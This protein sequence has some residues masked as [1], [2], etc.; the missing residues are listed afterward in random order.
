MI[1]ITGFIHELFARC[2]PSLASIGRWVERVLERA[3]AGV[4]PFELVL[5]RGGFEAVLVSCIG[6]GSWIVCATFWLDISSEVSRLLGLP[7]DGSVAACD[8][9]IPLLLSLTGV[10]P[11]VCV[12]LIPSGALVSFLSLPSGIQSVDPAGY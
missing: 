3:L 12:H 10:A 5:V 6:V 2:V 4:V 1:A 7:V 9:R 11:V 8:L